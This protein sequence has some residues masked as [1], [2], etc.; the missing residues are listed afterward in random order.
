MN[1]ILTVNMY[2]LKILIEIA[3][4]MGATMAFTESGHIRR[5][6]KKSEAFKMYGRKNVEE[7]IRAGLIVLRKDGNFSAAWRI[8]RLEIESVKSAKELIV[9]FTNQNKAC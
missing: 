5:Y 2:Q 9:L 6:L 7:W 3:A 4:K 1:T 8:D